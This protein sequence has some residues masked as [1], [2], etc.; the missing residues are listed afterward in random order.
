MLLP[1]RPHLAGEL[2]ASAL[3]SLLIFAHLILNNLV[4]PAPQVR[5][6]L[7]HLW[8]QQYLGTASIS[9]MKAHVVRG[10]HEWYAHT[11]L[12]QNPTIKHSCSSEG[13]VNIHCE[14]EK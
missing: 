8:G 2:S 12:G 13:H 5:A 3:M 9:M 10:C 1:Q 11:A 6:L 7:Q 14:R 4:K